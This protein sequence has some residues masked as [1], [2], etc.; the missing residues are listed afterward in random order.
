VAQFQNLPDPRVFERRW[1]KAANR[2]VVLFLSRIHPKKRLELLLDAFVE[3]KRRRP[4]AL[5]VVAGD[6]EANYVNGLKN[7]A[8][9]LGIA[10]DIVWTGFLVG[11]DKLAA[12][13]TARMFVLPSHSENFGIAV[14]EALAAGVPTIISSDVGVARD[15]E[16]ARA[17]IVVEQEP[18]RLAQAMEQLLA[19]AG[20][21]R[22]LSA[23]ARKLAAERYSLNAMGA[24]LCQL[25]Q[26]ILAARRT[27]T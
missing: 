5:L 3:L 14:V 17:G 9:R 16:A 25:Y 22:Q 1:P 15:I 24:S 8:E 19:D 26:E 11:T 23:N 7:Q 20:L 4:A 10:D 6:G 18:A 27:K 12:F 21:S 13:S 2:E